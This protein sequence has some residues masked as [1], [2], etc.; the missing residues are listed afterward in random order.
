MDPESVRLGRVDLRK[1]DGEV[2]T[3]DLF[4][5]HSLSQ[6]RLEAL[7]LFHDGGYLGDMAE[8][9]PLTRTASCT[10]TTMASAGRVGTVAGDGGD[11]VAPGPSR[12]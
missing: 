9:A 8:S 1:V 10:R 4:T 11:P 6:A 7:V 5:K 12:V 2:N 3:A